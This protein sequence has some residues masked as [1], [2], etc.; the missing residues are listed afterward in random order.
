VRLAIRGNISA[1]SCE[2]FLPGKRGF[3]ADFSCGFSVAKMWREGL[4]FLPIFTLF[5]GLWRRVSLT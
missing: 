1:F 3:S 2:V 4:V 5:S